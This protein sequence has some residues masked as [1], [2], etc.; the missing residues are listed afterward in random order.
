MRGTFLLL[1]AMIIAQTKRTDMTSKIC[2]K[3]VYV[4]MSESFSLIAR[5]VSGWWKNR[6]KT[7]LT[8]LDEKVVNNNRK[9]PICKI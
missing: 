1:V 6:R 8:T 2:L 9:Y 5:C 4:I 7:G 3:A